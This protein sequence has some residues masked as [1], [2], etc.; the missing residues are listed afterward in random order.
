MTKAERAALSIWPTL[1]RHIHNSALRE[2][3]TSPRVADAV[4]EMLKTNTGAVSVNH[5]YEPK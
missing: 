3:A 1:L 2:G 5:I 4:A